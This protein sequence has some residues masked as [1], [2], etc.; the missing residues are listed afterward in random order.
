MNQLPYA[1]AA[2]ASPYRLRRPLVLALQLLALQHVVLWLL[3]LLY[4][5]CCGY[6]L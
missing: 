6:V 1:G 2:L 3:V 5:S 4:W